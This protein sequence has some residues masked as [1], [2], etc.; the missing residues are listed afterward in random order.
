MKNADIPA[1]PVSDVNQ[2]DISA[3]M[4]APSRYSLPVGMGLTKR[5]YFAAMAM[6]GALS[7]SK[8]IGGPKDYAEWSLA[9]AEALLEALD[10]D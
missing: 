2:T 4:N 1:M 9:C 8:I 3:H 5:E 6:Q 7:A 10:N